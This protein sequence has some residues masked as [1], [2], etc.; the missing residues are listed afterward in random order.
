VGGAFG[1][2]LMGLRDEAGVILL[3]LTA[4]QLLW[5]NI[6][7][8]GPPAL[9]L[10]LDRDPGVMQEGP[11]DPKAP[12]LDRESLRF[13]LI[14]GGLKGLIGGVLLVVMPVIGFSLLETRT[15]IFL[16]ATVGQLFLAYPARRMN[17]PPQFNGTLLLAVTGGVGIQLLTVLLPGLRILLGLEPP[18]LE[19]LTLVSAAVLL[20]WGAAEVYSRI[21][22]VADKAKERTTSF[23]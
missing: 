8:D 2:V 9:A 11:R 13:I 5:V 6:I 7:T 16:H 10:G 4:V 22:L 12:L 23:V 18:T 20:T 19:M 21:A 17:A 14:A 1:A 15:A 3:P